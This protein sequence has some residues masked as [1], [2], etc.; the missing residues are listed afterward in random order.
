MVGP[1]G[2]GFSPATARRRLGSAGHAAV[3]DISHSSRR[4]H[5]PVVQA[6]PVHVMREF[7]RDLSCR[8]MLCHVATFNQNYA[9]RLFTGHDEG[10]DSARIFCNVV[11]AV[12]GTITCSGGTWQ[13]KTTIRFDTDGT[14]VMCWE[15]VGLRG[16][17]KWMV[18][19]T[20]LS[21]V[22]RTKKQ[23]THTNTYKHTRTHAR[24][25]F[26]VRCIFITLRFLSPP[27]RTLSG[28]G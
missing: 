15:G 27:E 24:T 18:R 6:M 11:K 10:T 25:Q 3:A 12:G 1:A 13:H 4:S 5:Y 14:G 23:H 2:L 20:P 17:E 19:Y 26:P 21:N 7:C 8:V 28:P 22:E 16:L 9:R